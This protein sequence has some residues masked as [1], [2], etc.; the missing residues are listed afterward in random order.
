MSN[1]DFCILKTAGVCCKD[2]AVIKNDH[3]LNLMFNR[4]LNVLC[5]NCN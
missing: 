3:Q 4:P 2:M 5:K 1:A